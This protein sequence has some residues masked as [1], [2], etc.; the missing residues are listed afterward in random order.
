[1]PVHVVRVPE[2]P[3][4]FSVVRGPVRRAAPRAGPFG[5][6]RTTR[7]SRGDRHAT[8][9]RPHR[10]AK[11]PPFP[12]LHDES[13]ESDYFAPCRTVGR[14]TPRRL[15][16]AGLP[17]KRTGPT[18]RGTS[19]AVECADHRRDARRS[20]PAPR[21]VP[22]VGGRSR[23]AAS[24]DRPAATGRRRPERTPASPVGAAT[25]R[26]QA[27][28]AEAGAAFDVVPGG[29]PASTV[30]SRRRPPPTESDSGAVPGL[31]PRPAGGP[32]AGRGR[33]APSRIPC[34]NAEQ[35]GDAGAAARATAAPVRVSELSVSRT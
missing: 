24:P 8:R 10:K 31:R 16:S 4:L 6:N 7:P 22:P 12:T 27:L 1:M 17:S 20:P 26:A 18:S 34:R 21:P 15:A 33:A 14:P 19:V 29:G 5:R 28:T 35:D 32:R 11:D 25:R 23:P 2:T 3:P 30:S 13:Q 9:D